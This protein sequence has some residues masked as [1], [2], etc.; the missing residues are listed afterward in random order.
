MKR[1][2]LLVAGSLWLAGS[3]QAGL[4]Y[5]FVT[6]MARSRSTEKV[7]GRMWIEGESYRAEFERDGKRRIVISRDGDRTAA[8]I[9]P[10]KATWSNRARVAAGT[11][12]RSAQLFQWPTTNAVIKGRPKV[13]HRIDKKGTVAGQA[14]VAHLIEASFAVESRVGGSPLRGK[15]VVKATIWTSEALPELPMQRRRLL[16]GYEAVDREL[17][18]A[19][20]NIHGMVLRHELE[21]K[22]TY[23]GG[24]PQTEKTTT[25]IVTLEHADIAETFF[26]VPETYRYAGPA[27]P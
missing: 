7:T 17:E 4:I 5:D 15:Y 2:W 23:E 20:S 10:A 22:R 27:A 14:A 18:K 16:T 25:E 6:T 19:E 26:S 8:M 1:P 21:V 12:V 3:L 24:T 11:S 9:D 13:S